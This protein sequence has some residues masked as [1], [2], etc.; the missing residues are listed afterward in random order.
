[1]SLPGRKRKVTDEQVNRIREW[2]SFAE[3]CRRIGVKESAARRIRYGYE[4]KQ[5][6][7]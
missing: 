6:S 3:L 5:P 7:P 1:M 2:V 4:Y